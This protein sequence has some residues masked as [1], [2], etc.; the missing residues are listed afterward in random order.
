MCESPEAVKAYLEPSN[1]PLKLRS[2]CYCFAVVTAEV[3]FK[4]LIPPPSFL[5]TEILVASSLGNSSG[6]WRWRVKG[7]LR[8]LGR[9]RVQK[10]E[11]V[12]NVHAE[13]SGCHCLRGLLDNQ[14]LQLSSREQQAGLLPRSL[15]IATSVFYVLT[16]SSQRQ[17]EK[18]LRPSGLS[19]QNITGRQLRNNTNLLLSVRDQGTNSGCLLGPGPDSQTVVFLLGP[20]LVVGLGSFLG[21]FL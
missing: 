15:T 8:M 20:H 9:N 21:S 11:E 10:C 17:L 12:S 4:V 1:V 16:S 2:F 7:F 14:A 3:P 5:A 6:R 18:C 19:E 13:L